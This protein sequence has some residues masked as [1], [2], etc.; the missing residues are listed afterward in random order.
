MAPLAKILERLIYEK[1]PLTVLELGTFCGYA[2]ILIAQSLP[3]GARIYTVEMNPRKAAV[4][5][6]V[7]R[8]AGFDDDTVSSLAFC[9]PACWS[10]V[11]VFR[12]SGPSGAR[13]QAFPKRRKQETENSPS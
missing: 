12:Q 8:L 7:I 3:L 1:A 10:W 13:L 9:G 2:T 4:A 11:R 5:E 6:K